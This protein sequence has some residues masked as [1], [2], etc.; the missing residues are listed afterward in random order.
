KKVSV[1]SLDNYSCT[2]A[3]ST[4]SIDGSACYNRILG[5]NEP[6][7]L[8]SPGSNSSIVYRGMYGTVLYANGQAASNAS[9]YLNKIFQQ[10]LK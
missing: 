10:E 3:N 1:V 6:M 5:S 8:L 9:C 4:A 7:V 2:I